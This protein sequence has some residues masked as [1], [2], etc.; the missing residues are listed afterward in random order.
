MRT[1]LIRRS[2]ALALALLAAAS[3]NLPWYARSE[4]SQPPTA[5][6][7]KQVPLVRQKIDSS[8]LAAISNPS[9]AAPGPRPSL[10]LPIDDSRRVLVDIK[11][12]VS[13]ELL[14][15]IRELGG[16]VVSAF[17]QHRQVRARLPLAKLEDLAA[18]SD[19]TFIR[20]AEE[21]ILNEPSSGSIQN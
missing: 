12:D 13:E 3:L 4:E 5:A 19:V 7:R 11:A 17:P 18:R 15:R 21:P 20:P 9:V 6:P 16:S 10:R 2:G 8:L 14:S 1:A